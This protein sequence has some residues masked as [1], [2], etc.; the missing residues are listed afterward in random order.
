MKKRIII[1]LIALLATAGVIAS[2]WFLFEYA[3][4]KKAGEVYEDLKVDLGVEPVL[5]VPEVDEDDINPIDFKAL[6]EK[7]P[8]AY[9]WIRIPGTNVDYPIVQ[10]EGDNSYYLSHT[11]DG[12]K[13]IEGAIF[14]EEYNNKDFEDPN[15]L[16]YGHNMKNGS[17]FRTLHRYKDRKFFEENPY[18]YIYQEG[19]V[20]KYRIFAAY[21]Y[22]DRHIMMSFDFEDKNVFQIYLNSILTNK[23][24]SSNI[25]LMVPVTVED[26]IIT[27]S[28][29][30]SNQ[31]Q[32]YLV[33]AVL[34][35]EGE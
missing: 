13:R 25:D 7:Y 32:R 23:E 19:K 28:T 4:E 1:I 33:Q 26:K 9:A 17:M 30:T 35:T 27:L 10:R 12:R 31:N 8:D 20:L 16:I 18:I 11:I 6:T 34:L 24:I 22:D 29:C 2:C 21:T 15:T 5:D 14:T 3:P